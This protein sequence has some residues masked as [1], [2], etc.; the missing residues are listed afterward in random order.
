MPE[1]QECVAVRDTL[2]T[3]CQNCI[4]RLCGHEKQNANM[5]CHNCDEITMTNNGSDLHIVNITCYISLIFFRNM[6][7]PPDFLWAFH[8]TICDSLNLCSIIEQTFAWN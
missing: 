7:I 1:F 6:R 5:V 8:R 2:C 4:C 3:N